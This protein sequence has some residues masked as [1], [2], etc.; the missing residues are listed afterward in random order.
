MNRVRVGAIVLRILYLYRGSPQRVFPIF[1]WVAVDILLWGFLTRY[2][3]SVSQAGFD[4][5]PALLGAVLLWDFLTRVMQGVTMAFFED[6]WSRNFLNLFASPLKISEYLAGL[7]IAAVAAS[8]LSL[9]AM[10]VF[11][12]AAFGLSFLVYGTALAP[13]VAV[14][15]LTG[16]AMGVAA[17]ALV[18]R[19]GPASEWLI[20]PIPMIVSPFAGVFYPLHVLP[21][22]MRAIAVALPP[23]YVFEG[24]RAVVAG[25]PAPW[26]GL[27][28]AAGL[29]LVYL[30]SACFLFGAVYKTAIR[31]GLIARYSAESVS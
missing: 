11:A 29:A 12:R 18:L 27:A 13:F 22:W 8:L 4:F 24:M 15:F 9:V 2:L 1:I 5:V 25:E 6:V 14:L 3:N 21:G 20:W 19:L 23:S 7:V 31:T 28:A 17:A 30:G 16:I 26:G 10:V